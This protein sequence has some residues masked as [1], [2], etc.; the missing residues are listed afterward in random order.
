MLDRI[1]EFFRDLL[2]ALQVAKLY[3]M[4]HPMFNKFLDKAY[5][6]LQDI[7]RENNELVIGI[8][9]EELV[10]EK[11]IFIELSKA[12]GPTIAY[13]K[14]RGIEKITFSYGVEKEELAKFVAFLTVSKDQIKSGA[15][16][17]IALMGIKNISIGKIQA[18][19]AQTEEKKK[20]AWTDSLGVYESASEKISKALEVM[21]DTQALD[22]LA[23]RSAVNNIM[24]NLSNY[25]REFLKLTTLK[26]H[27]AGTYVHIMNVSILSMYFS[28]KMGF[29]KG[30]SLDI[31]I[32]ALF[33]DIGKLYISRQTLMKSGMLTSQEYEEIQSHTVLGAEILLKL[34][35]KLG[36]LPIVVAFEHHLKND[37]TGYPKLA[38]AHKPH[39]ASLIVSICD[40]YDALFQRR[41]YKVDY[42][43]DM[44]YNVMTKERGSV[45][46]AGLLDK[47]FKIMGVWPVGSIVK[48]NDFRIAVV[49]EENEEDMNS[50][51]VEIIYPKEQ[52]EAIDLRQNKRGLR[53]EQYLN[54]WKEGKEFLPLVAGG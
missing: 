53:I 50:P 4:E 25:Y 6:S 38:Y 35:D 20:L 30:D 13:L 29:S 1:E 41:G 43:P 42:S 52:K 47:F 44:I 21:F 9:G 32:A 18:P 48:L 19:L 16:E 15:Q 45:F 2:A 46:D 34:V 23:I 37:L 5:G 39:T 49:T 22:H 33:H 7:L 28:S 26:R 36:V 27:D 24:E 3:A 10:F 12:I 31:G 54:P 40:V 51:R 11:E 14:D 8:I 17:Y